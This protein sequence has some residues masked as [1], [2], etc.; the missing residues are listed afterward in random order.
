MVNAIETG[1]P[2][3]G[4]RVATV[5]WELGHHHELKLGSISLGNLDAV[6]GHD[7]SSTALAVRLVEGFHPLGSRN[8][9]T[10][11]VQTNRDRETHFD[12][13][14]WWWPALPPCCLD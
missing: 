4:F 8:F 13:L 3:K 14:L 7:G 5:L 10:E 6:G 11:L 2:A 9:A 12:F 1:L